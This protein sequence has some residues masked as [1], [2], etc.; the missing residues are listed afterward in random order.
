MKMNSL[1]NSLFELM[2][3]ILLIFFPANVW[4]YNVREYILFIL[5]ENSLSVFVFVTCSGL[6][7]TVIASMF[8]LV[9]IVLF[10]SDLTWKHIEQQCTVHTRSVSYIGCVYTGVNEKQIVCSA[11]AVL[12][13][14]IELNNSCYK[15]DKVSST[16]DS[17]SMLLSPLVVK[18]AIVGLTA[19]S[20]LKHSRKHSKTKMTLLWTKPVLKHLYLICGINNVCVCVLRQDQVVFVLEVWRPQMSLLQKQRIRCPQL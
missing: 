16:C 12:K 18:A 9:W 5:L 13:C 19:C 3:K 10:I 20:E 6:I 8:K 14:R 4:M 2:R 15:N 17:S 11:A 7:T 1:Y